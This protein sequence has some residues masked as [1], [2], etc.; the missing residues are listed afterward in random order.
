MRAGVLA[1]MRAGVLA[2]MILLLAPW[3]TLDGTRAAAHHSFSI[4]DRTTITL[5]G[6]IRETLFEHPHVHVRIDV[7]GLIW[8]LDL[9]SPSL[10]ITRGLTP[11]F[12]TVG[13]TITVVGWPHREGKPEMAPMLITYEN[14]TIRLRRI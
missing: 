2:A 13:R 6:V 5:T 7:Q 12:L 1:A 9:P 14:T 8:L 4:Y 11:E 3:T 10:A